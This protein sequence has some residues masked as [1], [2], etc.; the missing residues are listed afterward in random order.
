M[1]QTLAT[2]HFATSRGLK[3]IPVL[4]KIDLP[5]A[6]PGRVKEQLKA[7]LGIEPRDV[8]TVSAKLGTNVEDIITTLI[9]E[10]KRYGASLIAYFPSPK[11]ARSS[12]GGSTN[13]VVIDSEHH[14]F[15]GTV[16]TL[17]VRDGTLNKGRGFFLFR[18]I[19]TSLFF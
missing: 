12:E 17:L 5:S 10:G 11:F 6:N 2:F 4:N 13:C 8:L 16:V 9:M 7:I 15:R 18:F 14:D 19:Y 3:V 1:A